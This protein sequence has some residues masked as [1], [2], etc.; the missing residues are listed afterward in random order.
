ME[1]GYPVGQG[2]LFARPMPSGE[3][4]ELLASGGLGT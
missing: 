2:F 3:F 4:V 1:I